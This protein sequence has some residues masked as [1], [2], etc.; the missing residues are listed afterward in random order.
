MYLFRYTCQVVKQPGSV[1][2][3]SPRPRWILGDPRGLARTRCCP[4]NSLQPATSL[5]RGAPSRTCATA[6]LHL[7]ILSPRPIQHRVLFRD[8]ESDRGSQLSGSRPP[9]ANG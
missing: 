9:V 4:E 3:M 7:Q 8:S 6:V 1:S 5:E 2:T